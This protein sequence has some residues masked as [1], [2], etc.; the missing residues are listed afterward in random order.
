LGRTLSQKK[1]AMS[2]LNKQDI[3][4]LLEM[5]NAFHRYP[6]WTSAKRESWHQVLQFVNR[7]EYVA[8][9][10]DHQTYGISVIGEVKIHHPSSPSTLYR[11]GMR[12]NCMVLCTGHGPR[13][14]RYYRGFPL[15]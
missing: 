4:K 14:S 6:T 12:D 10:G 8:F 1:A 3:D 7:F 9:S 11:R 15:L 2:K 5:L 13:K